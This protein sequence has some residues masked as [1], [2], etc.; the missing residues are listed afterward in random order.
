MIS[1]VLHDQEKHVRKLEAL[2]VQLRRYEEEAANL[3]RV[4]DEQR[5]GME[6]R[7]RLIRQLKSENQQRTGPSPE[8]E[9]L[10]AEHAQCAQQIQQ[11]QQQ[12]E[13]LMKQL[14]DQAEEILTTK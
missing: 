10:K 14:E 8:L 13:T 9:Q 4:L 6:E 11:K 7:D 12:L 3:N 2:Q 5:N 1:R